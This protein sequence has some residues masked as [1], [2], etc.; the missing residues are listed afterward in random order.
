MGIADK[1]SWLLLAKI[2]KFKGGEERRR[3]SVRHGV[4]S[5]LELLDH[6]R[7]VMN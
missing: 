6:E 7:D 3:D 5:G 2:A 1:T 4:C